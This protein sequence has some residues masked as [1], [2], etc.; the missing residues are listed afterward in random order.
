MPRFSVICTV[1]NHEKYIEKCL[2]SIVEQSSKNFELIIIDDGSTDKT[3]DIIKSFIEKVNLSVSPPN[4]YH[5]R[6]SNRG[7]SK[8]FEVGID[9]SKGEYICLMD[10]DDIW[11]PDK[12]KILELYIDKF[13]EY[14]MFAHRVYVI[15]D[16]GNR[17]GAIRPQG[18][19]ISHGDRRN[20]VKTT[21]RIVSPAT[22][23][24]SFKRDVCLSLM[25]APLGDFSGSLDTY[26]SLGAAMKAPVCAIDDIL[27]NYRVHRKGQ[28][29]KRLNSI[30]GLEK[31][32]KIQNIIVE[33][34]GI[35]TEA[36]HR[37]S[38]YMRN[39]LGLRKMLGQPT[40]HYYLRLMRSYSS[41]K[42]FDI[43]KKIM[44]SIFWSVFVISPLPIAKLMWLKFQEIQTGLG[45]KSS[46]STKYKGLQN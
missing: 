2:E 20:D 17:T 39:E 43:I 27:A 33:S 12:L 30:N 31:Q 36:K 24:L 5:K 41:D 3:P 15:D 45:F 42:D 16:T 18:A 6:V 7:Q 37:N 14:G 35:T 44:L 25:P 21:A 38:F 26:L 13:P 28:Y 9:L 10:S 4:I 29:I 1:Y 32:I 11:L 40:K 46:I 23:A 22:S 8:A 34:L 19:K